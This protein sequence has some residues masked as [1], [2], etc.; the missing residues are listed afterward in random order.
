MWSL[1]TPSHAEERDYM[2][3]TAAFY[4]HLNLNLY[5][6]QIIGDKIKSFLILLL[7]AGVFS[8]TLFEHLGKKKKKNTALH[9]LW[10]H[11]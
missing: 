7:V 2:C 11:H 4:V 9:T 8:N 3:N 6:S 10:F 1:N 5:D